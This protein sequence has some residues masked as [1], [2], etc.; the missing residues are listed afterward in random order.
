MSIGVEQVAVDVPVEALARDVLLGGRGARDRVGDDLEPRLLGWISPVQISTKPVLWHITISSVPSSCGRRKPV[1]WAAS[2][3]CVALGVDDP[4][5]AEVV[6][7]RPAVLLEDD[8]LAELEVV[9]PRVL[10]VAVARPAP[11][12][13]REPRGERVDVLR[14]LEGHGSSLGRLSVVPTIRSPGREGDRRRRRPRALQPGLHG[15]GDRRRRWRRRLAVADRRGGV[16]RRTGPGRG[17]SRSPTRSRWPTCS[18]RWSSAA[19]SPCA[20]SAPHDGTSSRATCARG[21]A[22]PA[23]R[24]TSKRCWPRASRRSSTDGAI[25]GPSPTASRARDLGAGGPGRAA[26]PHDVQE[27][28]DLVGEPPQLHLHARVG[29]LAGVRLALVAQRVEPGRRDVRRR[30]PGRESV[31]Q[32]A[33]PRVQAHGPAS[34]T[35]WS[36]ALVHELPG[37]VE[38]RSR[39]AAC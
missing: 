23:P 7:E 18:R 25:S 26:D 11:D 33:H 27:A 22:S 35:Y 15:R 34:G 30:Q 9:D 1:S 8:L 21:S 39:T 3:T 36:T 38:V 6:D 2:R 20:R 19:R 24:R 37:Q 16:V 4:G 13:P 14:D 29:E 32:R 10:P 31:E 17:R 5:A 12:Q 28:V